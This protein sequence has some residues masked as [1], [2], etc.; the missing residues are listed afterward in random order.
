MDALK[1]RR[2][3]E[4]EQGSAWFPFKVRAKRSSKLSVALCYSGFRGEK[5]NDKQERPRLIYTRPVVR[6]VND[7]LSRFCLS[8]QQMSQTSGATRDPIN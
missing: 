1:I 8:K 7:P 2:V 4:A 5:W 6:G 3:R